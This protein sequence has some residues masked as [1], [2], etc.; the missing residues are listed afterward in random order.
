MIEVTLMINAGKRSAIVAPQTTLLELLRDHF[1][2]T[3][4]KSGCEAGA[5]GACTVLIDGEARNACLTLA[6]QADG[7]EVVTIE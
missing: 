5:C 4:V 7:C 2:L 6:A 1:S 3:G